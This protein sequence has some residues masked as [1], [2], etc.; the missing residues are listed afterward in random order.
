MNG[1]TLRHFTSVED[2]F[3]KSTTSHI[4]NLIQAESKTSV[5]EIVN[6]KIENMVNNEILAAAINDLKLSI[7]ESK[8]DLQK[9]I[10]GNLKWNIALWLTQLGAIA[11]FIKY[12]MP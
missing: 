1:E 5:N 12:L 11:A 9:S 10:N 8:T 6:N 7:S 3:G 2:T 4:Y